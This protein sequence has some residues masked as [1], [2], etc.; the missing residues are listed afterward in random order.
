MFA[1]EIRRQAEAAP[2]AALPA[3]TAALWRAYGEGKV[4]EAAA[5]ALSALI[6]A[7]QGSGRSNQSRAN[8]GATNLPQMGDAAK[9]RAGTSRKATGS[10]PRTDASL[11]RRRRWAASGRLPPQLAA[12]FTPAEQAALALVAAETAR[13]GD[14]RLSV[15][16]L[17]AVA[18]VSET[19]A[20]NALREARRLGLVSVEE[21]RLT[22][23]RSDTNVVRIV[24]AEWTAWLRLARRGDR[25]SGPK[26]GGCKSPNPTPTVIPESG[27]TRPAEPSKGCRGA[28]ADPSRSEL[29]RI[30][31]T[32]TGGR[33]MR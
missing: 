31:A 12:R 19:T 24:S 25:V 3:V 27:K 14:C 22:G 8:C 5:E 30:R 16:H 23:W 10:R 20:R 32:R 18:G 1:D 6:E 15:P 13:R 9:D 11:E 2:R 33:A 17:A 28:A 26:G 7:R 21:R 4:S 29:A